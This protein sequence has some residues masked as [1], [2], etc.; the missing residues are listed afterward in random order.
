MTS[1]NPVPLQEEWPDAF[2]TKARITINE[3]SVE[4][5]FSAPKGGLQA[6]A[7]RC[8]QV[9]L[10]VEPW[11]PEDG[12]Q[13]EQVA[14]WARMAARGA[15][16]RAV[17]LVAF[18][19]QAGHVPPPVPGVECLASAPSDPLLIGGS[20]RVPVPHAFSGNGRCVAERVPTFV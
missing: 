10:V 3:L 1:Q 5:V 12:L 11:A 16:R 8:D 20:G 14:L 6:F 4:A 2:D 15:G 18:Q 9:A 17:L 19:T 7:Q 13:D